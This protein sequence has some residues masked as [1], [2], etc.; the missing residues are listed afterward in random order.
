MVGPTLAFITALAIAL[1]TE[2]PGSEVIAVVIF[3]AILILIEGYILAPNVMKRNVEL[4]P[5][6]SVLAL[7]TGG[8]LFGW[9]GRYL[10][11]RSPLPGE[12]LCSRWC[13]PLSRTKRARR[14]KR[15]APPHK[16]SMR[17]SPA[18]DAGSEGSRNG[19]YLSI[20]SENSQVGLG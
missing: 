15:T 12:S 6:T 4:A 13:F 16:R 7:L 8:A 14:S 3:F 2:A 17:N 11:S 18:Y 1:L 10:P 20:S 19:E 9:W 5:V